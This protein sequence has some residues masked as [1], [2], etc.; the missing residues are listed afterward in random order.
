MLIIEFFFGV[1]GVFAIG[2]AIGYVFKLNPNQDIK[3]QIAIKNS[4]DEN[5]KAPELNT[6]W[7][8]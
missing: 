7:K 8:E 2:Y 4:D 3:G 1:I 5:I 6:K